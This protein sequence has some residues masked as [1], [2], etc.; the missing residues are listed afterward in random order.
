[1]VLV[2][3]ALIASAILIAIISAVA[4]SPAG[5][6]GVSA[7]AAVACLF[8]LCGMS[9]VLLLQS[10]LTLLLAIYGSVRRWSPSAMIRGSLGAGG[11]QLCRRG[12]AVGFGNCARSRAFARNTSCRS[13]TG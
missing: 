10:V 5:R 6:G 12:I 2:A 1:M 3:V 11:R 9:Q 7:V 8:F 13:P 4:P